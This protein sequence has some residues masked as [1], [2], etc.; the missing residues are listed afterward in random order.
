M[1]P[2]PRSKYWTIK[3]LSNDVDIIEI[4]QK[5]PSLRY[6]ITT[7]SF[8]YVEFEKL[9]TIYGI[10]KLIDNDD[11]LQ[12]LEIQN[13]EGSR[14]SGRAQV[15]DLGGHH[16][17]QGQWKPENTQQN[18]KVV[19]LKD[20]REETTE[21]KPKNNEAKLSTPDNVDRLLTLIDDIDIVP[22]LSRPIL[23]IYEIVPELLTLYE[24]ESNDED[25]RKAFIKELK[26]GL[27]LKKSLRAYDRLAE[28]ARS[29]K[30]TG[31][32]WKLSF[33]TKDMVR[34]ISEGR[35][36]R[37]SKYTPTYAMVL[38]DCDDD[39]VDEDLTFDPKE[40]SDLMIETISYSCV[41]SDKK[42]VVTREKVKAI[43]K[44]YNLGS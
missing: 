34:I 33:V 10:T 13:W 30:T 17:E 29:T 1:S 20:Q 35:Q 2:K 26:E 5:N 19:K 40:Y 7:D 44:S 25:S 37:L 4:L 6:V 16:R 32:D 42:S 41:L 11:I 43:I 23:T 14:S 24:E 3:L 18:R 36:V 39:E 28:L 27:L 15:L 8:A 9:T 22:L 12:K 38:E 31:L 21:V